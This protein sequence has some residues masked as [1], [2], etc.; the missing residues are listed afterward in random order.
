MW[1]DASNLAATFFSIFGQALIPI[2]TLHLPFHLYFHSK[3]QLSRISL[4]ESKKEDKAEVDWYLYLV[5]LKR[6]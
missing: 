6:P 2:Q 1:V 4:D 5:N 3:T